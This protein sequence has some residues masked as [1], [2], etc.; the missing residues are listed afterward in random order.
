MRVTLT[1]SHGRR[2]CVII[3][4][5]TRTD[6]P[7]AQIPPF[8]GVGVVNT[9]LVGCVGDHVTNNTPA[10]VKKH[11]SS[12]LIVIHEGIIRSQVVEKYDEHG[13]MNMAV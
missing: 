13:C 9:G 1:E 4:V 2:V 7:G 12:Y 3:E 6:D 10:V 11:T 8:V 5:Q